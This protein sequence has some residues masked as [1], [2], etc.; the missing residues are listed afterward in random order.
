MKLVIWPDR[1]PVRRS[2]PVLLTKGA[3]R[4]PRRRIVASLVTEPEASMVPVLSKVP[5]SVLERVVAKIVPLLTKPPAV[6]LT[7]VR[8]PLVPIDPPLAMRTAELEVLLFVKVVTRVRAWAPISTVPVALFVKVV[9]GPARSPVKAKA[10]VFVT[11]GEVNT[12]RTFMI[13]ELVTETE[14]SMVSV[15]TKVPPVLL[16]VLA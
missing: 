4:T 1:S 16:R 7:A 6:L 10:P 13:A 8:A 12:P 14:A 9:I 5:V 15:L 11:I 3:L 2:D